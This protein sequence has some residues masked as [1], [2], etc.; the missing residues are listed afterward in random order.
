MLVLG[1]TQSSSRWQNHLQAA[2]QDKSK[3]LRHPVVLKLCNVCVCVLFCIVL[4]L[5]LFALLLQ[6]ALF[7]LR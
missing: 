3:D 5:L 2:P 7:H 6:G 1:C 4:L